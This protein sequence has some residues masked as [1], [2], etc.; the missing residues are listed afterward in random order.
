MRRPRES[1]EVS[2]FLPLNPITFSILNIMKRFV[3]CIALACAVGFL[4]FA[5]ENKVYSLDIN[6]LLMN[7]GS[8]VVTEIWDVDVVEGTEWYLPRNNMRDMEIG[9]F[10]VHDEKCSS[11]MVDNPWKIK[12]SLEE[13]AGRCGINE[14]GDGLEL[15]WGL[16][17]YGRHTYTVTY[18]LT[19]V[20]QSLDDYDMFHLQTVNSELS[21]APE[22]VR[23]VIGTDFCQ[24]D[25][26]NTGIWGFGYEGLAQL[27]DGEAVFES[28]EPFE[29]E[30]SMICLLRFDKGIFES[31]SV[32]DQSFENHLEIALENSGYVDD[33]PDL[34]IIVLAALGTLALM[35][36]L[37][38]AVVRASR[39]QVLGMNYGEVVESKDIPFGGNLYIANQV[40]NELMEI[41]QGSSAAAALI[42]RMIYNDILRVRKV[43]DENME[44]IFN[45][46]F[47]GRGLDEPARM[48]YDMMKEASGDDEVLQEKE[49]RKWSGRNTKKIIKWA[50]EIEKAAKKLV[51]DKGYKL[52]GRYN[53]E[54]Q[55]E[56]CKL[57]GLKKYLG[58][59]SELKE[60][61]LTD[62]EKLKEYLV[63]ATLFEV[64][65]KVLKQINI[66]NPS[67]FEAI[68]S[69]NYHTWHWL[70]HHNTSLAGA[71]TNTVAVSG[72]SGTGGASSFGGGRGFSG[73]GVGG[74]AR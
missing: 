12:R 19:N 26:G 24:L 71:I 3:L 7:D 22:K 46:D 40:L 21:S 8:V 70:I 23:T 4:A 56:A 43:D 38:T 42:I 44:I 61:D 51:E 57:L 27:V 41:R 66:V 62:V 17:S 74:G 35:A 48:L 36:F 34:L 28:S 67:A 54:F 25:T 16:G 47:D 10:M 64:A 52:D 33:E 18:T 20:V 37:I 45:P 39:R 53:A 50:K 68:G 1:G 30:T 69:Y 5:D 2:F 14:T 31:S 13:K 60:A 55:N 72:A 9:D 49:F 63:Y 6:Y 32:L 73:G 58:K 11:Y 65:D 29:K 15:C 59:Y